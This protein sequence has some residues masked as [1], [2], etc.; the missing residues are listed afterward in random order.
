ME[1]LTLMA[2]HAHPDDESSSTGGVL[3][4][5]AAEGIRTVVVTCTNGE[6]GDGPGG[7]KP[8]EEGHD[9]VVVAR[10]RLEELRKACQI[11]GVAHLE[12]LGYHDS[13]MPDWKY[14]DLPD[15]FCNVPLEE[16]TERLAVLFDRYRPD[17][18]V[19]YD[20][21]GG[22]DHPDHLRASQV[23]MAAVERTDIARKAYFTAIRRSDFERFRTI[24]EESGVELPEF[25]EPDAD[26]I[27]RMDALEARITT[28]VDIVPFLERKRVALATHASQMEESFF[29]R[30][31][32]EAFDAIFARESFIRALDTTGA[33][34]PEDDLFAGIR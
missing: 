1:P 24:M 9:E 13:G 20:S 6:L 31:P 3:A 25:P 14:K 19:T 22:Y 21:D 7:V 17:V 2:V 5:Y 8:G 27:R 28:N 33:P 30:I 26:W 34:V 4:R 32:A 15:A 23:T 29:G 12:L 18:I 10:T 16:S 11:L